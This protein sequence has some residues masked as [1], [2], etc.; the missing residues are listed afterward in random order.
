MI[1][2]ERFKKNI[3]FLLKIDKIKMAQEKPQ[4]ELLLAT[5]EFNCRGAD[6]AGNLVLPEDNAEFV[7]V[8]VYKDGMTR[9]LCRYLAW[10]C[11]APR[12]NPELKENVSLR[13]DDFGVCPYAT[14]G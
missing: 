6:K 9:P 1:T 10:S 7:I 12:C 13:E 2:I 14:K 11:I 8:K 5:H 4:L 3:A